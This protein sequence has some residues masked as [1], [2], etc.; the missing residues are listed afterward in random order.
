[1]CDADS[2][3]GGGVIGFGV[4][5]C[6][7]D[8]GKGGAIT[9][10]RSAIVD[11]IILVGVVAALSVVVTLWFMVDVDDAATL[12]GAMFNFCI[13]SSLS[14][15]DSR[16]SLHRGSSHLALRT[17]GKEHVMQYDG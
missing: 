17:A 14:R 2:A 12:R 5:M 16:A 1:M 4:K 11:N 15:L 3:V 9:S 13:P 7:D 8:E 10:A 6:D